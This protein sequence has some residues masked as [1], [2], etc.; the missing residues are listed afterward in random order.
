MRPVGRPIVVVMLAGLL[1]AACGSTNRFGRAWSDGNFRSNGERIYFTATSERGTE[2]DYARGPSPD[3]MMMGGRLSCASCH[4]AEASGGVHIM[5]MVVMDAPNIRWEEL[6]EHGGEPH[7][8]EDETDEAH[9]DESGYDFE[10]FR[11]AVTEGRHPDGEAL[12]DDMPRWEMSQNDLRDLAEYL[13]SF[14][15]P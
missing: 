1:V 15:A 7:E 4:G 13:Q 3:R 8:D 6:G 10:M 9:K 12:S 5:H 14:S 11:T 2:I